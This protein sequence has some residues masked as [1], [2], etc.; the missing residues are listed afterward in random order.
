MRAGHR[1][2]LPAAAQRFVNRHHAEVQLDFGL[3]LA[4]FSRQSFALGIELHQK[5]HRAFAVTDR[6]QVGSGAA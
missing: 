6:R 4:V 5:V 2:S 3:R 1:F